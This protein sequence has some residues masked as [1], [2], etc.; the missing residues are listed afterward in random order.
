[1][2]T[3]LRPP[4]IAGVGGGVGTTTLAVALR[5]R[6]GGAARAD[7]AD[8]V[9]CRGTLDSLHRA[10][11]VLDRTGPGPRPVLAVTL[12]GARPPRGPLR[13]LL[14]LLE[15]DTSAVVLLPRVPHWRTLADPLP[16]IATLLVD[17]PQRLPR[18]LRAYTAALRELAA[19]VTAS[20]R[21]EV[22]PPRPE[23]ARGGRAAG[24]AGPSRVPVAAAAG[25]TGAQAVPIGR[26]ERRPAPPI[27][28]SARLVAAA[29]RTPPHEVAPHRGDA[30]AA[31]APRRPR[32]GV[33]IL[34]AAPVERVG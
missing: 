11:G 16:E 4:T 33:R 19:A 21:L 7:T 24:S 14:P 10:A 8:I 30:A 9:V 13:A 20:G 29:P 2:V 31:E 1:V 23:E 22:P 17:P 15:P 6:D 18:P 25:R 34:S 26:E 3:A 27:V 5:G 12:D 28:A 32:R